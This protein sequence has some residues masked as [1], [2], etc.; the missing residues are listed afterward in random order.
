M[1][2]E[3]FAI[4]APLA[5]AACTADTLSST[6]GPTRWVK[7][8]EVRGSSPPM[9]VPIPREVVANNV[10]GNIRL[11]GPGLTIDA[12]RSGLDSAPR[13]AGLHNCKETV[14]ILDGRKVK[15]IRHF[16]EGAYPYRTT[17]WVPLHVEAFLLTANCVNLAACATAEDILRGTRF[18]EIA[19]PP[20]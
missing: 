7:L 3:L 5:L 6:P 13:C 8:F 1:R 14:A 2:I 20:R 12:Q 16:S 17:L 15:Y 11:S 9:N 10:N 19:L 4:Y 18:A